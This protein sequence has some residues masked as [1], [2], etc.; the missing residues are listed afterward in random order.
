MATDRWS[1]RRWQLTVGRPAIHLGT[2]D[3]ATLLYWSIGIGRILE[4]GKLATEVEEHISGSTL[5]VLG[6]DDLRHTMK[7]VSLFIL[8]DVII[9]RT[10]NEE[11]HI[12]ILLDGSGFT[13]VAQLWSL[14]FETLTVFYVTRRAERGRVPGYSTPWQDP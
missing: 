14:S 7:V 8:I 2:H 1:W 3:F 4:A 10:M 13:E 6:D 9:L 11:Y 5:T 12:G